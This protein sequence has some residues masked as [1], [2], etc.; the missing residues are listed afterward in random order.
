MI[1]VR[2]LDKICK[3]IMNSDFESC[4]SIGYG[5]ETTCY[6]FVFKHAKVTEDDCKSLDNEY[7]KGVCYYRL[8]MLTGDTN[9]CKG[10]DTCYLELAKRKR[11][12]DACSFF[13]GDEKKMCLALATNNKEYCY[14]IEGIG[15]DE[16]LRMFP[17]SM[18]DCL[19]GNR[20]DG[21]CLLILAKERKDVSICK[22]IVDPIDR[23]ECL[24][25]VERSL[26]WCNGFNDY[27]K[28][29]CILYYVSEGG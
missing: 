8:A 20:Y 9:Y 5:F 14:E 24:M 11:S 12:T 18:K 23:I 15:R 13:E 25:G 6:D 19:V 16:C 21:N 4:E 22:K 10:Y 27:Y 17:S 1:I 29:W 3:L 2:P 28:S 26:E 7:A